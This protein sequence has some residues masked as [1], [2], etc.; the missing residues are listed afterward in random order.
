MSQNQ[1]IS[2]SPRPNRKAILDTM[3]LCTKCGICHAH[4]P[5]AAVTKTFP[6]PKFSGPQAQRYRVFDQSSEN[7]PLLCSGCGVCTSVCPNNVAIT[8][9]ITLAKADITKNGADIS[10][11]QKIL[12]RPAT[13][14]RLASLFPRLANAV[15]SN[16]I[17]RGVAEQIFGI[18]RNAPLPKVRGRQF[19][20]WFAKQ[21]QPN[22]QRIALFTGCSVEYYD[23]DCA[24]ALTKILNC[25]G[26]HVDA[27]TD[28]CC[29]LPKLS[30]GETTAARK[31]AQMLVDELLPAAKQDQ[32]I[33][34]TSTSCSLTLRSKYA[35]Y[36]DMTDERST[37]VANAVMDACEFL[38]NEHGDY[39]REN[40]QE[41][42]QKVLYH[43]PCQLRDHRMGEPALELL[44][45][46]PNI[47]L[48]L[49]Q[50]DCCGIGGTYGYE[51][52]KYSIAMEVG[53]P[54]ME[55]VRQCKPDIIICDSET[56]RW[57]IKAQTGVSCKHP[58]Q[59][60][61][62]ALNLEGIHPKT[63][64]HPVGRRS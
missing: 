43:G 62:E 48:T 55:Q 54:L 12:N 53:K 4:C 36:L 10:L 15:L 60:L 24:I 49:S 1:G 3:A 29:S 46:I 27:P 32:I 20:K 2:S 5:V 7:S 64:L 51:K 31:Q 40:L 17:L 61:V 18:A 28:L 14:G 22:G 38:L 19:R 56:C 11:G 42:P 63:K 41:I 26:Y 58:V 25:L 59:L 52:N 50:A 21:T 13:I 33:L 39:L 47:E 57:N 34:S 6:G 8:D 35:S 44:R 23:P 30:S 16:R 45:L 9:I 37:S